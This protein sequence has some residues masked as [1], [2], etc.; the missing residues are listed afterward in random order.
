LSRLIPAAAI[1]SRRRGRKGWHRGDRD[2]AS[3]LMDTIGRAIAANRRHIAHGRR[4]FSRF[5][6]LLALERAPLLLTRLAKTGRAGRLTRAA[7]ESSVWPS[8]T[9][10]T[11]RLAPTTHAAAWIDGGLAF[12]EITGGVAAG[13]LSPAPFG[14]GNPRPVL[15]RAASRSSTAR[16]S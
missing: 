2:V 12:R 1:D 4:S 15:R 14:A 10:P 3:K 8:T 13:I 6:M 5:D 16:A 7:F 11:R 9:S